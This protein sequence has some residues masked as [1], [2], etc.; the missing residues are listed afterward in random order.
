MSKSKKVSKKKN[1]GVV[2]TLVNRFDNLSLVILIGTDMALFGGNAGALVTLPIIGNVLVSI[3]IS[4]VGGIL[5]GLNEYHT[6]KK[7]FESILDAIIC[8]FLISIPTPIMG[9][10]V[11]VTSLLGKQVVK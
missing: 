11:G 4:V 7:V 1:K 10:F 8:G 2:S 6:S 3:V 9:I 5:I